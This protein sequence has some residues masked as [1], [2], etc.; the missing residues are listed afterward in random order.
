MFSVTISAWVRQLPS[1]LRMASMSFA[2]ASRVAFP[3][4]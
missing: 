3:A 4:M 1:G 2:A